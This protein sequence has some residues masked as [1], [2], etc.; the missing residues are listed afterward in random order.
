MSLLNSAK[1]IAKYFTKPEQYILVN[2]TRFNLG[3]TNVSLVFNKDL[4]IIN[5]K[6]ADD[7]LAEIG[8]TALQLEKDFVQKFPDA[9]KE[10][11]DIFEKLDTVESFS[12]RS[13]SA[14]SMETKLEREFIAGKPFNSFSDAKE[15]VRDG[16][17]SRIFM[18]SLPEL[19]SKELK[20]MLNGFRLNGDELS[21]QDK[22]ILYKYVYDYP[23]SLDEKKKG[24]PIFEKFVEPLIQ[25]QSQ[26][27]V[28]EISLSIVKNLMIK[29]GLSIED[30][31]AK[32]MLS[33]VLI[34][35]L[36]K[37]DIK[38][39]EFDLVN[40]Y[41]GEFGLPVFTNAQ[42]QQIE[43]AS[44]GKLKIISRPDLLD[45]DK[46]PKEYIEKMQ[47]SIRQSGYRT[48]QGNVIH[49]NGVRGEFQFR[50]LFTNDFAEY[51]HIA[52][53]LRMGKNT[54][55]E[56]FNDYKREIS[57]LS[58]NKY[59]KYT[60]YLGEC[61]NYYNRKSLGLPIHKPKLPKGFNKILSEENMKNLHDVN[62]KRM[63]ELK[64]NF[65][66]SFVQVA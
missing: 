56:L 55:G 59:N 7:K 8:T 48:A 22:K 10:V 9:K 6:L 26:Q 16:I 40:N 30:V 34:E 11:K 58:D 33:D 54:L 29:K 62:E 51:E 57:K 23:M 52:Y 21:K 1:V 17:G 38:P 5:G 35:R 2:K 45:Y 53:D 27:V 63:N 15:L 25:K 32:G 36:Q 39:L 60:Q 37:E 65:V 14:G 31:R 49:K 28:D 64:K 4:D 12:F 13:K 66:P 42:L 41:R 44:G 18:K 50:D 20:K 61:Y 47:K 19:S 46:Y 43:K 3:D 24:F